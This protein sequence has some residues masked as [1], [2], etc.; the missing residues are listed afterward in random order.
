MKMKMNNKGDADIGAAGIVIVVAIIMVV[1]FACWLTGA[2]ALW[3]VGMIFGIWP[4][5]G[6]WTKVLIG[7]AIGFVFGRGHVSSSD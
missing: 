4:T 1:I 3:L 2:I 6:F 7:L 5:Y